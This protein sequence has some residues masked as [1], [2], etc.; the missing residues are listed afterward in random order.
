MQKIIYFDEIGDYSQYIDQSVIDYISDNQTRT[1]ESFDSFDL[2]AFDWFDIDDL[3]KEPTKI[4]IY[5]DND[6]LFYICENELSFSTVKE[7][8]AHGDTNEKALY[9]FFRNLLKP[10]TNR[11]ENLENEIEALDDS[12]SDKIEKGQKEHITSLRYQI[13]HLKKYYER[14]N[15]IFN[16]ICDNDNALISEH[17]LKYFEILHNRTEL[18]V[19]ELLNLRE[20]LAQ[21]KETYLEQIGIEQNNTMKVFTMVTSIFLPL[22]LI[23]GW[24]GMNVKMPEFDWPLGYPF[25]IALSVITCVIWLAAFKKKRWL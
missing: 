23:A 25:V 8:F 17:C 9:F 18:L 19:S 10:G 1:Y 16:E 24:Y 22:S 7:L 15:F 3:E 21:V 12:V 20:Y 11:L 2:I 5:I 14:L 13:L 6:D 4:L